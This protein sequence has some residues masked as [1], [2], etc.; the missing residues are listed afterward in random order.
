[1][2]KDPLA[3]ACGA[4][5]D[6]SASEADERAAP[7]RATLATGLQQTA[8]S[9]HP[10]TTAMSGINHAAHEFRLESTP[11]D[12]ASSSSARIGEAADSFPAAAEQPHDLAAKV[13]PPM[14]AHQLSGSVTQSTSS[15]S[16]RARASSTTAAEGAHGPTASPHAAAS[17]C[18]TSC[19]E[20]LIS[21]SRSTSSSKIAQSHTDARTKAQ[22]EVLAAAAYVEAAAASAA[23]SAT[24]PTSIMRLHAIEVRLV[25]QN[26]D[27]ASAV[28]LARCSRHLRIIASDPFAWRH[29]PMVSVDIGSGALL[30]LPSSKLLKY[31]DIHIFA[32]DAGADLLLGEVALLRHARVV[33][34]TFTRH[35]SAQPCDLSA[36][37]VRVLADI[38]MIK[39]ICI[40]STSC[41]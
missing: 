33:A 10:H 22:A 36:S 17:S 32:F 2:S 40:V 29:Q 39:H 38:D 14:T 41:E 1:M 3:R 8:A 23:A 28:R 35:T 12:G 9:A 11:S 31:L 25:M 4:P 18:S 24:D 7:Q 34:L 30:P 19:D 37:W 20:P 5:T 15:A 16:S 26:L 6:A 21:S 27:L 13:R